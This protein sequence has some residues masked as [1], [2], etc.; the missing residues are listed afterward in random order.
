MIDSGEFRRIYFMQ[1]LLAVA[2]LGVL[3]AGFV[4]G[5]EAW[6]ARDALGRIL[7]LLLWVAAG[8]AAYFLVLRL[9]GVRFT[10]VWRRRP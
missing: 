7:W 2:V 8:I 9:S 4:P 6:L 10:A 5:I 3:L 1:V